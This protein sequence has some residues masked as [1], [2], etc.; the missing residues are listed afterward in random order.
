MLLRP[1][2]IMK[3]LLPHKLVKCFTNILDQLFNKNAEV[4]LERIQHHIQLKQVVIW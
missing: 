1:I 3:A 2:Y 4:K